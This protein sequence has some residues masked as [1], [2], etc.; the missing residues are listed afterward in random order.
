MKILITGSNGYIA[1][2]IIKNLKDK[3]EIIPLSRSD[4]DLTK[5]NEVNNFFDKHKNFDVIIHTAITGGSRLKIENS[6]TID[7]NVKM[8]YNLLENKNKFNKFI[9]FGSGA[10]IYSLNTPYGISKKLIADSMKDKVNFLNMR[11]FACFDHNELNTRFI[12]SNVL[13]YINK[14]SIEIYENKK[15]DFFH[16]NDLLNLINFYIHE[17]KLPKE[18]NCCYKEKYH[19]NDI[20]EI[21]NNLDNYKVKINLNNKKNKDYIG[22]FNLPID[23]IGLE[24]GI[25]LVYENLKNNKYENFYTRT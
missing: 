6:D 10:E 1:K 13:K 25:K 19:L 11:I 4:A 15:M 22:D 9:S 20:A 23:Y 16:M 24:K 8:Y 18:I 5:I 21:I 14:E 17:K 2:S 12:K 3:N 7:Q